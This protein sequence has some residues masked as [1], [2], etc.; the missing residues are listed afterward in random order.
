VG[1]VK[2]SRYRDLREKPGPLLY[3]P[4]KQLVTSGYTLLVRTSLQDRAIP[5]IKRVI[6]SV[7]PKLAIYDVHK[8]QDQID[9]GI[10]PERVLSFLSTLFSGLATLLCSMRIYGLIAYAVSR[11]T[12][13][14]GVRFAIGAQKG[15]VAS[16]FLR[17][18]VL[19][20]AVGIIL[21]VPLALASTQILKSLLYGIAPTD[22]LILSLTVAI[23]LAAGLLASIV[24]VWKATRIEPLQALRYE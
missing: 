19:L 15:D 12:R 1:L 3:F 21:G 7:D 5:D 22:P 9:Q 8:L 2:N 23:F 24:P 16:L 14:I 6:R 18:S 13:E 4:A 17:E 20:V 11:R 10:S